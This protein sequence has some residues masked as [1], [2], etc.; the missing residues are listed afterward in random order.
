MEGLKTSSEPRE[1]LG[2]GGL[3][4]DCLFECSVVVVGSML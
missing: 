2:R 3:S 1:S 4:G